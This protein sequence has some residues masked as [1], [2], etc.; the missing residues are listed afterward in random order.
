M[1]N[2]AIVIGDSLHNTYGLIRSLGECGIEFYFLCLSNAEYDP[3]GHSRY[4][5]RKKFFR[6]TSI[7][8]IMCILENL[9]TISGNKY[10]ICTSDPL[11]TWVDEHEEQLSQYFITPCRGGKIGNLFNKK[12]QCIL[13]EE[14]GFDVPKSVIY[15]KDKQFDYDKITYPVFI[16]PLVSSEGFKGDITVCHTQVELQSALE[17]ATH[18]TSFIIQE[19]IEDGFDLDCIG[20]RTDK[21]TIVACALRKYRDYPDKYG[22]G[23]YF[24]VDKP[25]RYGVDVK[26]IELFLIKSG[27]YGPFSVEFIHSDSKNYFMEVN[28]R[29]DGLAYGAT[30]AGLNLYELYIKSGIFKKDTLKT[31]TLMNVY[32]DYALWKTTKKMSFFKW[33]KQFVTADG[34]LD[35]TFRDPMPFLWRP[36]GFVLR[37][38]KSKSNR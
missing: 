18:T 27:Y 28:F 21:E 37:R 16:K 29:N 33:F 36:I 19:Y 34:W 17:K 22:A 35:I 9:K 12:E 26:A 10:I 30:C 8:E 6:L 15:I 23:S 32:F 1:K 38:L 3:I 7:S 13:A 2:I 4:V 20:V 31:V 24:F 25:E 14:Y 5:K 11:A